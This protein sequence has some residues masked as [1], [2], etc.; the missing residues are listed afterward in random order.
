MKKLY[1]ILLILSFHNVHAQFGVNTPWTWIKGDNTF[2]QSGDYGIQGVTTATNKPS[3]RAGAAI[4]TDASGNTY[5]YSGNNYADMWK[6]EPANN[7]WTWIQGS[8]TPN[9]TA[10]YGTQ[11][12]AN[13]NNTPGPRKGAASWKDNNGFFWLF[14]GINK[15]DDLWKYDPSVNMWTWIKGNNNGSV[16][17]VYTGPAQTPGSRINSTTWVDASGNLWLFGGLSGSYKNDIWKYDISSNQWL[18]YAA[19][20]APSLRA[21]ASAWTSNSGEL[22]LFGG[23][24]TFENTTAYNDLWKYN[25]TTNIWTQLRP[26]QSSDYG[27]IGAPT[28]TNAPKERYAATTWKDNNGNFWM[29]GGMYPNPPC[30]TACAYGTMED[31]WKYDVAINQWTWMKGTPAFD[32]PGDYGTLGIAAASNRP[33]ARTNA[34]SFS[35]NNGNFYLFGGSD[36]LSHYLNDLWKINGVALPLKLLSFHGTKADKDVVLNW[37]TANETSTAYFNIQKSNNGS[38]FTTAGKVGAIETNAQL[39]N[40]TY[41]DKLVKPGER[42]FY[43]LEIVDKDGSRSYSSTIQIKNDNEFYVELAPNPSSSEIR[44]YM[45]ATNATVLIT[46]INGKPVHQLTQTT[47]S[48][49]IYRLNISDLPA[50]TY[51]ITVVTASNVVN[52]RFIKL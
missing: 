24:F 28:A 47:N 4:W 19:S 13:A 33:P 6:Y 38:S 18:Y 26:N 22:C 14:G 49:T 20:T 36:T 11:N 40:Y 16:N 48:N 9:T 39:Q 29:F 35:D 31:L 32:G 10:I 2:D 17:A 27:T 30:S 34:M 46:D 15:P 37:Q 44:L 21:N 12:I 8:N 43:R 1:T 3:A 7:N 25:T 23:S 5:I 45:P 50:G 52:K 51:F 41:T 42:L